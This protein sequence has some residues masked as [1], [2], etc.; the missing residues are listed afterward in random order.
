MCVCASHSYTKC[1][2]SPTC[3][4]CV[5]V[6][7]CECTDNSVRKFKPRCGYWLPL[8]RELVTEGKR[9]RTSA[10]DLR[11]VPAFSHPELFSASSEH[12]THITG[13]R[14]CWRERSVGQIL[15]WLVDKVHSP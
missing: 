10:F 5:C 15:S 14:V 12:L 9:N 8:G 3:M 13:V 1:P 7:V 6:S 4:L 2:A 11:T